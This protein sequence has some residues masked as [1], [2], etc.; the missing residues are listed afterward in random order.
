ME[1]SPTAYVIL[2]MLGWRPMSGYEIKALVD[3]STRFFWAASYGQIYP[4]LRRL[5]AAGLIEGEAIPQGGRRRNV[6]RLTPAGRSELQGWLG[7]DAEA[8]E[9]RDE[10]LLKLFFADAVGD[11]AA[12]QAID[13]KRREHERVLAHLEAIEANGGAG[14]FAAFVLR[15]G[16]ECNRWQA[17][18][19]ERAIRELREETGG[20]E[21]EGERLV[22]N[23]RRWA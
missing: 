1:L 9:L 6:Y 17:D 23:Q 3:K 12:I 4:E 15:Y 5:S 8:F 19:C 14:G 18:W 21:R 7:V 11:E 20:L 22:S 13:A 16:I 10:G 2:G